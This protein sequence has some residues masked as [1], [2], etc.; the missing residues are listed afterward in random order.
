MSERFEAKFDLGP[1]KSL[2][3]GVDHDNDICIMM[4]GGDDTVQAWVKPER[5]RAIAAALLRAAIDADIG[6]AK[7]SKQ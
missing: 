2:E 7:E 4:D 1:F 5:A 3:I 6:L